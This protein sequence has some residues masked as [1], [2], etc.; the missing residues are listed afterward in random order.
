M[1]H[2]NRRKKEVTTN[3]EKM[4]TI[5]FLKIIKISSHFVSLGLRSDSFLNLR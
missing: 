2:V 1:I 5:D 4:K 3:P